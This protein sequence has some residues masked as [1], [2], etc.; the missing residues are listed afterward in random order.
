MDNILSLDEVSVF[1]DGIFDEPARLQ[2]PEGVAVHKDDSVWCGTENGDIMRI[3]PDGSNM[4][5]IATTGGWIAGIAFDDQDN[6]YACDIKHGCVFRLNI[7]SREI[8]PFGETKLAIPNYP[9]I[10]LKRNAL[11]V[12]DS[13]SFEKPGPGIWRYDLSSGEAKLWCHEDIF[14]AN[15][16]CLGLDGNTLYIVESN[17]SRI[18]KLSNTEDGEPSK[19]S[20][21]AENILEVP[22]GLS[23]DQDGNIYVSCYEPSR[24]YKLS[25]D[26]KSREILVH[27]PKATLL[28]HPTNTAFRGSTLFTANL[29]RWHITKIET[30][31]K[32]VPL[33][34]K[35]PD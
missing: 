5:R 35:I 7:T 13:Y 33:P 8:A 20:V 24:I 26:G 1:Y 18:L 31:F 4:E 22:D 12:T 27:D 3:E 32:G 28:C 19:L 10:D 2:H 25:A 30:N 34:I 16:L 11:Y 21:F 15:G 6:L 14:F 23:I 17:T 29:G 9:A